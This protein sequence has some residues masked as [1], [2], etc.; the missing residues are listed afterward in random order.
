[1]KTSPFLSGA[2]VACGALILL[3][4]SLLISDKANTRDKPNIGKSNIQLSEKYSD[5][6][7]TNSNDTLSTLTNKYIE[8]TESR[9]KK[10]AVELT[11]KFL[12]ETVSDLDFFKLASGYIS[13][14]YDC[15]STVK[16]DLF[17]PAD[18][19]IDQ[20]IYHTYGGCGWRDYSLRRFGEYAG[21]NPEEMRR[22]ALFRI[23]LQQNHTA[24]EIKINGKFI[25]FD[26]TFGVY[27]T[28]KDGRFLSIAEARWLFPEIDIFMTDREKGNLLTHGNP[29]SFNKI[30]WLKIDGQDLMKKR[31][32]CWYINANGEDRKK[33]CDI[34]RT[35]FASVVSPD[36]NLVFRDLHFLESLVLR[37]DEIEHYWPG[38]VGRLNSIKTDFGLKFIIPKD[39]PHVQIDFHGEGLGNV[40]F[41]YDDYDKNFSESHFD[42]FEIRLQKRKQGVIEITTITF[43]SSGQGGVLLLIPTS[44]GGANISEAHLTPAQQNASFE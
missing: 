43:K 3:V 14:T 32:A 5:S 17:D 34:L 44:L 35:Y 12:D 29:I 2:I 1:M 4:I 7:N 11:S 15:C 28:A 27:F 30:N 18:D 25:F 36:R 8:K 19:M 37:M 31:V 20:S 10:R 41:D 38:Y 22:V 33:V 39:L 13:L 42:D 21:K 9:Y 26:P 24:S 6:G 16:N 23:P 40:L